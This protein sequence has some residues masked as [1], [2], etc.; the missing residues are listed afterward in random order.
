MGTAD[1]F[2]P[3]GS[4]LFELAKRVRDVMVALVITV[5]PSGTILKSMTR[6]QT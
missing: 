3:P 1:L 2:C 4:L 6:G 5:N